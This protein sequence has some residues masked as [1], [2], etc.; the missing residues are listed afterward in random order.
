MN[1]AYIL[2]RSFQQ[3]SN[4]LIDGNNK[5]MKTLRLTTPLFLLCIIAVSCTKEEIEI[6]LANQNSQ[7]DLIIEGGILSLN[8]KQYLKIS[9]PH[10]L[11]FDS[12]FPVSG[13]KVEL[14]DRHNT[15]T[16]A[17]TNKPGEYES[18][19]N[20]KAESGK[21]YTLK[22][23]YNEKTYYAS[24]SLT[25]IDAASQHKLPI[26]EIS[27]D[28]NG[29]VYTYSKTHTFGYEKANVWIINRHYDSVGHHVP[30]TPKQIVNST[31]KLYTHKGALPQGI[32]PSNFS[33]IGN[34]GEPNDTT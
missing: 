10:T 16:Y 1:G 28:N 7:I 31:T 29:R 26:G 11:N 12:V 17:E 23:E 21:L 13:A 2:S 30:L 3:E 32:F 15:F 20:I 25:V 27:Y 33:S 34:A 22:V 4:T 5:V 18:V 19:L 24:D 6:N 8:G 9:K 14:S